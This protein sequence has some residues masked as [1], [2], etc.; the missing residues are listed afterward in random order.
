MRLN[1][2]NRDMFKPFRSHRGLLGWKLV[3]CVGISTGFTEV[4]FRE[5]HLWEHFGR[6]DKIALITCLK[7]L[8]VIR[9]FSDQLPYKKSVSGGHLKPITLKP[10]SRIFRVFASA[11]SAFFALLLCGVSSNP[12]FCRVRGAFCIFCIFAA[13]GSNRCFRKSDRPA[14]LWPAL[15]DRE[16]LCTLYTETPEGA[17]FF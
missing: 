11:F 4:S 8:N 13:S 7:K 1:S 2:L 14:L 15:G 16:F 9:H 17:F 12:C 6:T 5:M 3:A 10:I